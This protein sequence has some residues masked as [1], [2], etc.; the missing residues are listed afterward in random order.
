MKIMD[1]IVLANRQEDKV[2]PLMPTANRLV[3]MERLRN[4]S[5]LNL[6]RSI[7]CKSFQDTC[8]S[9]YP[10]LAQAASGSDDDRAK[11]LVYISASI[12]DYLDFKNRKNTMTSAQAAET[13]L[14]ILEEFPFLQL[15]D[16]KLFVRRLKL[17]AYGE[18][19]DLD[20]QVFIGWLQ[21][22][23]DEKRYHLYLIQKER[24]RKE[25]EEKERRDAESA[26]SIEAQIM[27]EK[28]I[29]RINGLA[30]SMNV[31]NVLKRNNK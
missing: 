3:V 1:G 19:Y 20:G 21:K 26:M 9:D 10:T 2:V 11:T 16:L 27:R 17:N 12:V 31:N 8:T 14:L 29:R 13:A 23:V 6:F 4:S 28:V 15:D 30:E 7:A 5:G 25:Q 22:Y 24:E 18:V